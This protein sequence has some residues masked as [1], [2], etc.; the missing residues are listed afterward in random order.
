MSDFF[1]EAR[2]TARELG[3]VR[4]VV[5]NVGGLARDAGRAVGDITGADDIYRG[6][7]AGHEWRANRS[8][9]GAIRSGRALEAEQARGWQGVPRGVQPGSLY[10]APTPRGPHAGPEAQPLIWKIEEA[11]KYPAGSFQRDKAVAEY[12]QMAAQAAADG[13]ARFNITHNTRQNFNGQFTVTF[14]GGPSDPMDLITRVQR[15]TGFDAGLADQLRA[16][17]AHTM[18]LGR[19]ASPQGQVF[20]PAPAPAVPAFVGGEVGYVAPPA[21]APAVPSAAPETGVS[22]R[23]I[24]VTG[25]TPEVDT[26]GLIDSVVSH[27]TAQ[28]VNDRTTMAK[29][30]QAVYD[31]LAGMPEPVTLTKDVNMRVTVNG[32][33]TD[34]T[35]PK[36]QY[37]QDA[38]MGAVQAQSDRAF[39]G[40]PERVASISST[41]EV[42]EGAVATPVRAPG[43]MDAPPQPQTAAPAPGVAPTEKH[44]NVTAP[45]GSPAPL[46]KGVD[47]RAAPKADEVPKMSGNQVK[48]LQEM[49][50]V[51]PAD[52]KYGPQTHDAMVAKCK[53]AGVNPKDVDLTKRNDPEFV[54]LAEKTKPDMVVAIKVQTA[55]TV[56][57]APAVPQTAAPAPQTV[58]APA[59]LPQASVNG[60]DGKP[61]TLVSSQDLRSNMQMRAQALVLVQNLAD[62]SVS[63]AGKKAA[64]EAAR[65]AGIDLDKAVLQRDGRTER[66][67]DLA[68]ALGVSMAGQ[69]VASTGTPEYVLPHDRLNA[70]LAAQGSDVRARSGGAVFEPFAVASFG[71]ASVSSTVAGVSTPP[72]HLLPQ[73]RLNEQL[74]A[75][76]SDVRARG[77]MDALLAENGVA[78]G[79]VKLQVQEVGATPP[80]RASVAQDARTQEQRQA[81]D[82]VAFG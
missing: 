61:V 25:N 43:R 70:Q 68:S 20:T 28:R 10:S 26:A 42:R 21:P 81:R 32:K 40:I 33:V 37:T 31:R 74:A 7:N 73:D 34:I 3:A 14:P 72:Q 78:R 56:T 41:A 49:L 38:L 71:S 80:D 58:S 65:D 45:D 2:E 57:A 6:T 44:V 75:Q 12:G 69:T 23:R 22:T 53:E 82:G 48:E 11:M 27:R 50:G 8:E 60:P 24:S 1:R 9:I 4:G 54:K 52:G 35:I 51:K 36:G 47:G 59:E 5:R 13:D 19:A 63:L 18:N 66:V 46:H 15:A 29:D 17:T 16:T 76:G 39:V 30:Q 62:P 55:Q 64:L 67:A 79:E 77:D